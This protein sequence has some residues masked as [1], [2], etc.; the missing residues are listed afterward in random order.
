M[1]EYL[2]IDNADFKARCWICGVTKD[3]DGKTT[4]RNGVWHERHHHHP[5][6]RESEIEGWGRELRSAVIL[7]LT[8]LIFRQQH[9]F[10]HYPD[11][12]SLMP[13]R[14]WVDFAKQRAQRYAEA[15]EWQDDNLKR[16]EKHVPGMGTLANVSR[17]AFRKM[18]ERSPNKRMLH[19]DHAALHRRITGERE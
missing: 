1:S 7:P 14:D 4:H 12:E 15:V 6:V 10:R 8:K 5:W 18:Q 16:H 2:T 17:A 11:L 9:A 13:D 3:P 19:I